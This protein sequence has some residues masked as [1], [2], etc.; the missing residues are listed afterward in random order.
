MK[1]R[2]FRNI[3]TSDKLLRV[4]F[5]ARTCIEIQRG[6]A[7]TFLF[8]TEDVV[9]IWPPMYLPNVPRLRKKVSEMRTNEVGANFAFRGS[10]GQQ[11]ALDDKPLLRDSAE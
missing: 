8:A 5:D 9:S 1:L 7:L 3:I 11:E 10:P 4:A 2:Q 6:Y